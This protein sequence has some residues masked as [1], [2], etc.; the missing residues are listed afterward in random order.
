VS[1][2][3]SVLARKVRG[4]LYGVAIGDAV[5]A[6]AEWHTPEEIR[7]RY[8]AIEGFVE[9]WDG[10]SDLGKGDGR[11]TD[12]TLMTRMLARVYLEHGD[13][14]DPFVFAQRI[15][16]LIA[17]ED[18]WIAERGTAMRLVDRLFYPEKW[19]LMRLRLANA[20]PRLGGVGNMVNCGAAMYASP[21]GIVN[22][23]DPVA[24]YREAAEVF[25]AH[26]VSYGLEAAAV[27]AACVAE[28]FRPGASAASVVAT[29]Q[30]LAKEG[31]AH[32]IAAVID[33]AREHR[34][35]RTAIQ[36]L[37]NAMRPFD[38]SAEDGRGDRGNR[39]DD[40]APS[41]LKAI[42]EVPI[43]LA[44]VLI[45]DGDFEQAIF[46]AANYG[47]DNDSI[48]SMCGAI[49]GAL[50]GDAVIRPEWIATVNAQNRM[51]LDPVAQ[52]LTALTRTLQ[53]RQVREAE[54]RAAAF[55]AMA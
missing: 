40:W 6:P 28:A 33:V 50:H 20:D 25:A 3:T 36:P 39:T 1:S 21:V 9:P 12:D 54:A 45:A 26:Q 46:G 41:R 32:A 35:W 37:R 48:A 38:G 15:V 5:G 23:A 24:A 19:L 51:D 8:G 17:D 42:E 52:G 22:A 44:M 18:I 29:A 34:T 27:M 16:P 11:H 49:C 30:A 7:D 47:R 55:A 2:D 31:T 14:L 10:P 53:S 13:H 4:C 43:A